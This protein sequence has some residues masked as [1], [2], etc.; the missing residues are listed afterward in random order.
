MNFLFSKDNYYFS[1][2][3][4]PIFKIVYKGK[5]KFVFKN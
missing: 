5:M 2:N 4:I 3:W 1:I